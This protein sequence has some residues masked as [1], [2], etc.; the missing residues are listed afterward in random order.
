MRRLTG[1]ATLVAS[2]F[3][4]TL[5]LVLAGRGASAAPSLPPP[6]I[7]F[8]APGAEV[9][10]PDAVTWTQTFSST[11]RP[12][13]VELVTRIGSGDEWYVR[14]APFES[15]GAAAAGG[16]RY[17]VRIV[18]DGAGL[19][20]ALMRFRF[21]VTV[22]GVV[23]DG[24]DGEVRIEDD[25]IAWRTLQG[26]LVRLH[27]HEGDE[28]FA[29][30]ALRIA[31]DAAASTS[32]LLG[33]SETDAIDFFVYGDSE[34]FRTA[35]P[36]TK[37][38]IAGLSIAHIRTLFAVIRPEQI[39]SDWVQVV[40]PHELVHLV[41]DTATANA[42]HGLPHWLNEGLA[43]YLSEGLGASDRQR[44]A[45]AIDSGTLLPLEAIAAGFPQSR[46]D[47][48]YLGYAEGTSA[49]DFFIDQ[50][51]EARL[52]A[53]IRSYAGGVTDDEAFRAATGLDMAGFADAWLEDI[54]AT[55]PTALGP[56]EAVPGPTPPSWAA[57]PAPSSRPGQ[58]ASPGAVP[59]PR[60]GSPAGSLA[61]D[62][63]TG[64]LAGMALGIG[65]L[66]FTLWAVRRRRSMGPPAPAAP[67]E[68]PSPQAD[69]LP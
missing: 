49:V 39:G 33:V 58:T 62:L 36:G 43:T 14:D 34:L 68:P 18:D 45:S 12:D 40:I 55:A 54:G 46:K 32:K 15:L 56:V 27:W 69:P 44:V 13:R 26:D 21:R 10:F 25:R 67:V 42:Y 7:T 6:V 28:A 19:P 23:T 53:L 35:L 1:P 9:K 41:V 65:I 31:E 29:R 59:T 51:G 50:Y 11:A 16:G 17:R 8:E 52:V 2:A 47:L 66:G 61:D 5:A 4:V 3:G 57:G 63:L 37:E 20:N 24:P 64:T 48:F 30:R 22:E 38:F 60:P